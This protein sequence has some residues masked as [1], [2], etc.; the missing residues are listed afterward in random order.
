MTSDTLVF[1]PLAPVLPFP[2][3]AIRA[4]VRLAAHRAP[5]DPEPASSRTRANNVVVLAHFAG[6]GRR[7]RRFIASP[8][9]GEAA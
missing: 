4:S 7:T 2:D 8:P 9:D 1:G 6:R 5:E 3:A